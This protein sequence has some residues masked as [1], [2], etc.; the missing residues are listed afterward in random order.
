MT[1][2]PLMIS[3]A[4]RVDRAC[5]RFETQWRNGQQLRI[6]DFLCSAVADDRPQLLRGLLLVELELLNAEGRTPRVD[7]YRQRFC[8]NAADVEWAF[9][10]AANLAK[11]N[12]AAATLPVKV[13]SID[14]SRIGIPRSMTESKELPK[15]VGRF[16]IMEVLGE[17]AFGTVCRAYDPQLERE[18]ALKMPRQDVLLDSVDRERFLRE[19]RAAAGLSH[20]NV[21]RVH[22]VGE[23]GGRDY[24]VMEL[25]GGMSLASFVQC[26]TVQP[27]QAAILVRKLA[28]A[29]AEAHAG[30]IVHRDLK[31]AN[32]MINSRGEPIIMD[33]GLARLNK[34]GDA[35]LTASGLIMGSPAYMSP[36]QARGATENIGPACDI[37]SLGVILYELLCGRRPF[38]GTVTEVIGKILHVE[39]PL[40]S[41]HKPGIDPACESICLKALA[42]EPAD[43]YGSLEAFAAA[44]GDCLQAG[45]TGAAETA[46]APLEERMVHKTISHPKLHTFPKTPNPREEAHARGHHPLIWLVAAGLAA[47][48]LYGIWFFA[49]NDSV[50]V[51][52]QIPLDTKDPHLSFFL[53]GRPIPASELAA[54]IELKPGDHELIANR[55]DD[56]VKKF[57]FQVDEG[58][59]RQIA[60]RDV[61]PKNKAP[62]ASESLATPDSGFGP[63]VFEQSLSAA[64]TLDHFQVALGQYGSRVTV[65]PDGLILGGGHVA[66]VVWP[67]RHLGHRYRV[68]FEVQMKESH[69][70]G[71][72]FNGPGYGNSDRG[73]YYFGFTNDR[74]WFHRKGVELLK[75]NLPQPFALGEW[76]KVQAE[77]HDGAIALTING[78]NVLQWSD[79][80]PLTGPLYG[81]LGLVG[82]HSRSEGPVFRNLQL[83]S[84]APDRVPQWTPPPTGNLAPD[85][86][87]LY[88]FKP[89]AQRLNKDW[90]LSRSPNVTLLDD[91]VKLNLVPFSNDSPA[92]ILSKPLTHDL[93]CEIEFT[94]LTNEALNLQF[95]LWFAKHA[96]QTVDDYESG[97]VV[98]LPNG[99]GEI[100]AQWHRAPRSDGNTPT[101]RESH[102]DAT[103][104]YAPIPR[105]AYLARL[106]THGD[107]LRVFLDGGLV[108]AA[109]R[110]AEVVVPTTP[111]FLGI[112]QFFTTSKIHGVRIYQIESEN[113]PHVSPDKD[114]P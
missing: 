77:I 92:M 19:A 83:W 71:C 99:G 58:A 108:L 11:E 26:S 35:Q 6:E 42:K 2:D 3:L 85:G 43:R 60:V 33:F 101:E 27:Q 49:G 45:A 56:L 14:T 54:P 36:E 41:E 57:S 80:R 20:P 106:E 55:H 22:E 113:G 8:R 74:F 96:P 18:V 37:Y 94:Y 114:S 44:L 16:Q 1:N 10:E 79:T 103:S 40:L 38:E 89:D 59:N 62:V 109:R 93:A 95:M 102:V 112:R 78:T 46:E 50:S 13:P 24:I 63:V 67:K 68:Q 52:I 87:L 111:I 81:W 25:I 110:P 82:D 98:K 72:L 66:P 61:T 100:E 5:D 65:A 51:I 34:T 47:V 32:I 64:N 90:W 76:A 105:R 15:T 97:W 30:G 69:W 53:D 12:S 4:E 21:C 9:E 31:P 107:E 29:L 73:S 17:G 88:E 28:L 86:P 84:A 91:A 75:E 39:P 23:A 7:D 104:Y 48:L 70:A